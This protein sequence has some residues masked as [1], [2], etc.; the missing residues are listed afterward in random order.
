M[1]HPHQDMMHQQTLGQYWQIGVGFHSTRTGRNEILSYQG[2]NQ[3][4]YGCV[5]VA[6]SPDVA[7]LLCGQRPL[8][9]QLGSSCHVRH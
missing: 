5:L 4:D 3:R 9:L 8:K 6:V 1:W 2:G 7:M